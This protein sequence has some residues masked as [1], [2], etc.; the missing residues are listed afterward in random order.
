MP[1]EEAAKRLSNPNVEEHKIKTKVELFKKRDK[2]KFN[3]LIR[4]EDFTI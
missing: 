2:I 1:L 3:F 4:S